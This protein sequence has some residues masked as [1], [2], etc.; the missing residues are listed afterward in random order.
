M[1][2]NCSQYTGLELTQCQ[3]WQ[4]KA[5]LNDYIIQMSYTLIVIFFSYLI[6]RWIYDHTYGAIEKVF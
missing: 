6:L 3:V 2:Y 5:D 1:D 4:D